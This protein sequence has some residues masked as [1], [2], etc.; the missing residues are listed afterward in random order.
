MASPDEAAALS[1]GEAVRRFRADPTNAQVVL[2][3]Y[4]D[5]PV[6]GAARRY[7]ASEEFAEVRRL[8]GF[9]RG[10]SALDFGA[11]SGIASYA[12][13]ADGWLVT[14]FEPNRDDEV[15]AGAILRLARRG[16]D[17]IVVET[18]VERELPFSASAFDLVFA[19][20]VLHHVPDLESTVLAL[21]RVLRPGGKLLVLREHVADDAAQLT[22][23]LRSHPLHS[24][25]GQE[26]AFPLGEYRRAFRRAGLRCL[27]IWGP[28]ESILNYQPLSEQQRV[29][30]VAALMEQRLGR[31]GAMLS[32]RIWACAL[33]AWYVSRRSRAPGR[34][35]SFLLTKPGRGTAA[36]R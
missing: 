35:F 7:A 12:L 33:A 22:Q 27:R 14:A 11:G 18:R 32:S 1:W 21:T 10:R 8:T 3:N 29:R 4:F 15:G 30:Y 16:G 36:H 25:H 2:D 13:A 24:L 26:N 20:Q 28:V 31:V 23:F 17:R 6:E 9:G 19:R 34:L 5:L